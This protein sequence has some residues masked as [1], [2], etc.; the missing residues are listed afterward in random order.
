MCERECMCVCMRVCAWICVYIHVSCMNVHVCEWMNQSIHC[1]EQECRNKLI[2]W[3]LLIVYHIFFF[4]CISWNHHSVLII[5]ASKEPPHDKT[6]KMT[7]RPAKTQ[8]S[9]GIH[10]VWSESSLC[11]QWVA[12]DRSF[13]H[14]D[15]EDSDQTGQMPRLIWVFAGRTATLLVL[16][17]GGSNLKLK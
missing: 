16:T 7:V 4:L 1:T 10:P 5:A 8:I 6:N 12:K 13:L 3:M 2:T 11:A 17:W 14:A 9:L 15:S